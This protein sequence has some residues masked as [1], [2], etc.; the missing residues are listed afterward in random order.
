VVDL[1]DE[2]L[3]LGKQLED[4]TARLPSAT[5]LKIYIYGYLN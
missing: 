2:D 5:L 3:D 4:G 1:F